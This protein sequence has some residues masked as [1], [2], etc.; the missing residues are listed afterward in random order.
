MTIVTETGNLNQDNFVMA[1]ILCGASKDVMQVAHR[2]QVTKI[3]GFIYS[4]PNC[5]NKVSGRRLEIN[6]TFE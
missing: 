4:C 2:N 5:F 1:C 3:V 6:L